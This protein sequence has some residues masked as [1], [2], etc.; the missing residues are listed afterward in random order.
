MEIYLFISLLIIVYLYTRM[1]ELP[2]NMESKS[3][4][5]DNINYDAM[6]LYKSGDVKAAQEMITMSRLKQKNPFDNIETI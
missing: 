4:L 2:A 5:L 6:D 1:S 3:K